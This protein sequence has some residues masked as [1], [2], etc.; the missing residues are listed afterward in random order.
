MMPRPSGTGY[1]GHHFETMRIKAFGYSAIIAIAHASLLSAAAAQTWYAN[2]NELRP[3]HLED[4]VAIERRAL[5]LSVA[6]V[7]FAE[8]EAGAAWSIAPALVYGVLRRAQLDL[9]APLTFEPNDD[10]AVALDGSLLYALNVESGGLPALAVR[11]STVVPLGG[12]SGRMLWSAKAVATRTFAWGR[13]HLN[14]EH[15][16]GEG[17]LPA[18]RPA[19]RW[20]TGVAVDR[21]LALHGLLV[22]AEVYAARPLDGTPPAWTV[23]FGARYQMTARLSLDAGAAAAVTERAGEDWRISVGIGR[24]T[25][26]RSILPGQGVW[27]R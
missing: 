23:G 16:F 11:G 21:A 27:G 14:Y 4:A 19:Y 22:G 20:S 24:T 6:P 5:D 13:T 1:D 10:I 7:S 8:T 12:E 18:G 2:T 17:G 26:L 3:L 25:A 9:A 15:S